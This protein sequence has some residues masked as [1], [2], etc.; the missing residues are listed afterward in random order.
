MHPHKIYWKKK[1]KNVIDCHVEGDLIILYTIKSS[2]AI[3]EAIG[4]H[5][6]LGIKESFDSEDVIDDY[7]SEMVESMWLKDDWY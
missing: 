3:I 2:V 5:R 4:T 1:N 6:D 7:L